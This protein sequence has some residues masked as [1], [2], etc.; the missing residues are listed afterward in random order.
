VRE[1]LISGAARG[2]VPLIDLRWR[3]ARTEAA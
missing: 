1:F 3:C 2:D